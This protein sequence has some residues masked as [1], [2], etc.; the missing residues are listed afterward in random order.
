M[1]MQLQYSLSTPYTTVD[2]SLQ[3]FFFSP[4]LFVGWFLKTPWMQ[5]TSAAIQVAAI[6]PQSLL[7]RPRTVPLHQLYLDLEE[8]SL[9]VLLL[10]VDLLENT[11]PSS[12]VL[13]ARAVFI[14]LHVTANIVKKRCAALP[15]L[16]EHTAKRRMIITKWSRMHNTPSEMQADKFLS[17]NPS[18]LDFPLSVIQCKKFLLN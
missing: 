17:T 4:F 9:L 5:Q 11:M 13:F 2:F 1:G 16:S 8:A 18:Y 10:T 14:K 12:A 15:K 6:A 3:S 7:E